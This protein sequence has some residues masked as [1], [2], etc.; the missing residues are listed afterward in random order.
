MNNIPRTILSVIGSMISASLIDIA[1]MLFI[2]WLLVI[3]DFITARRLG[4]R[5]VRTG[6]ISPE[7]A[8]LS[9]H[10]LARMV[11]SLARIFVTLLLS[12]LA[13]KAIFIHHGYAT[14][15]YVAAFLTIWQTVSIL[16]NEAAANPSSW[17][18]IAR[19]ILID[20]TR[21]HLR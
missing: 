14:L 21:R 1:P 6:T 17:A 13:D 9:S 3:V 16:E 10:R 11:S 19:R 7:N 5:L 20:K 15:P 18:A 2:L 12:S 4:R 8:R